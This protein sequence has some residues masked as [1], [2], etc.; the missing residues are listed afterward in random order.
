MDFV[1]WNFLIRA[2]VTKIFVK[3]RFYIVRPMGFEKASFQ[4]WLHVCLCTIAEDE[5][6]IS[7]KFQYSILDYSI[8]IMWIR[9][10]KA[11]KGVNFAFLK[12]CPVPAWN[13]VLCWH[14][15]I[16]CA[17]IRSSKEGESALF[18]LSSPLC[19]ILICTHQCS[20]SFDICTPWFY[21]LI[22]LNIEAYIVQVVQ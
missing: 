1:F 14:Q 4:L 10:S 16:P 15:I 12:M 9:S 20:T 8:F 17:S 18:V 5:Y 22:Q 13:C 21:C 19:P 11:V 3:N 6:Q 2:T 7:T